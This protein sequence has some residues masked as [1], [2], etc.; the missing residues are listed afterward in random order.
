VMLLVTLLLEV[1][2]AEQLKKVALK[3]GAEAEQLKKGVTLEM[4]T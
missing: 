2:R 1:L 4:L 3:A